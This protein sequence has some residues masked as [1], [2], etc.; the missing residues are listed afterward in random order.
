MH[1]VE[2]PFVIFSDANTL[3]NKEAVKQ[4]IQHF[5][6]PS[7]G[8]VA[9]E[10]K[11]ITTDESEA[12]GVGEGF[13]W[14]YESALK[15]WDS[16]LYSVMGAAGELFAVRT[17]LYTHVPKDTILDDFVISFNVNRKGY[18]VKYE[19]NA[20]AREAPSASL[21]DEYKRKVRISAGGFQSI[22]ML[23]D[24][25]NIFRYPKI[26]WQYV[27]HRVLRW[28]LAPLGLPL[29]LISNIILVANNG[30]P[31]YIFLLVAQVLFYLSAYI[32]Y[33]LA[34]RQIKIKYFY[35]PFYFLFMNV[36]VYQ[37]FA[38]FLK[39][40]QSAIW[41]RSERQIMTN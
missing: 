38:R 12:E 37:G 27:S 28:T 4:I 34:N 15:K 7:V 18:T 13:Y 31:L 35:I 41:E 5:A 17:E 25:L 40:K 19:P 36:A 23:A 11:I 20:Y 2:T 21:A 30:G 24:L 16:E 32:G 22:I 1:L 10:K 8:A 9:G 14:K 33:Q 26:T 6:T 3:L 29:A 39:K